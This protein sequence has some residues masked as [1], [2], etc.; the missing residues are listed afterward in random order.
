VSE[1]WTYRPSDFLM[2]APGTYWRLFELHNAAWWPAQPLCVATG[3]AWLARSARGGGAAPRTGAAVLALAWG[4]V[5]ATFVLGRY[6]SINWA[7]SALATL[8]SAAALLLA[9]LATRTD[10]RTTAEPVR[11]R[12]GW[13][14][15]AWALAAHPL[16]AWASGRPFAQAEV[17]GL[18]PDPTAI[19]TLGLL[20]ATDAS[21][22]ATRRLLRAAR[23]ATIGWCAISA[24]TLWTM[25]SAQAAVPL[26]TIA[27]AVLAA[28]RARAPT[29]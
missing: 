23:A 19:A 25:G 11:R 29:R 18:A 12:A 13:L 9:L 22:I 4:F 6:A 15:A 8:P 2:F 16:L 21:S 3:L 7:A 5:G 24:A 20:L 10:L 14:L 28:G 26:A 17:I 27:A 1:W